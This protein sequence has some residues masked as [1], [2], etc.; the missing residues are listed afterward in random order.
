MRARSRARHS[1]LWGMALLALV[2]LVDQSL[3]GLVAANLE[4]G[5]NGTLLGI[6]VWHVRNAGFAL[7]FL[8]GGVASGLAV[9]VGLLGS[10]ACFATL[11]SSRPLLPATRAWLG[12]LAAG[13]LGNTADRVLYGGVVDFLPLANATASWSVVINLADIA[14]LLGGACLMPA[15]LRFKSPALLSS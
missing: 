8:T 4:Q 2:F 15:A 10:I 1:V 13:L 11:I 7:G 14:I 9:G 3:K 5:A 12:V 6:P